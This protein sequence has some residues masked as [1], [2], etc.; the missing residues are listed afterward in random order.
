V[1]LVLPMTEIL[2]LAILAEY[3]GAPSAGNGNQLAHR[4]SYSRM[5]SG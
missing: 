5:L 2:T 4:S 1:Q 3:N